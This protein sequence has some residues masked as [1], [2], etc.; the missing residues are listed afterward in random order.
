M[1]N[2]CRVGHETVTCLR[3]CP[4]TLYC[5]HNC[6]GVCTDKCRCAERCRDFG[7][8]DA[9]Q[10]IARLQLYSDGRQVPA[11]D[12]LPGGISHTEASTRNSSPE[13][14]QE[15]S[16]DPCA[17]D[18]AIRQ[19]RLQQMTEQ[20]AQDAPDAIQEKFFPIANQDGHRVL[21]EAQVIDRLTGDVQRCGQAPQQG[22]PVHRGYTQSPRQSGQSQQPSSR[23]RRRTRKEPV[24]QQ[25]NQKTREI[26]TEGFTSF[27]QYY[28]TASN[29][30]AGGVFPN[31]STTS[32]RLNQSQIHAHAVAQ[33]F[34]SHYAASTIGDL[35]IG[36]EAEVLGIRRGHTTKLDADADEL[37]EQ[38][39]NHLPMVTETASTE[40]D[41]EDE[42]E[43]LIDI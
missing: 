32:Q 1:S 17:H 42:P 27:R 33:R 40:N 41:E 3:P 4:R 37:L 23:Q 25:R 38:S 16:R 14:W 20:E 34:S 30:G 21:G 6:S 28:Y 5:G 24:Q 43:L 15:F 9:E 26:V 10:Q 11:V 8:Q 22:R 31:A 12:S 18:D 29:A 19:A 2:A 7:I 39:H 36:F 13:K 35:D